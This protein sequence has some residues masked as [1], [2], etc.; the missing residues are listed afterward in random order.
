LLPGV[1]NTN[2]IGSATKQIKN[3]YVAGA[4]SSAS[5]STNAI[6]V[7]S[8]S[9]GKDVTV[10]IH[11]KIVNIGDWNMDATDTVNVTHGLDVTKI[12]TVTGFILIDSNNA[13]YPITQAPYTEIGT[14]NKHSV[15]FVVFATY[16][17]MYRATGGNFDNTSFDS[18]G[19]NRGWLV[20]DYVD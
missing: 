6:T 10:A 14:Y 18:T 3:V 9:Q 13:I 15:C 16:I 11:R 1:D 19:F 2:D 8:I 4:V 20:I 5:I 12:R 17:A 7:N